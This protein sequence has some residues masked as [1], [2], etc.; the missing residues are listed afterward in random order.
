MTNPTLSSRFFAAVSAFAL[1]L[2]MISGT[3][4]VPSNASAQG[5]S[6]YVSVV[7]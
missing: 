4:A 6:T 5:A 7:A 1:S 2:A 3:V